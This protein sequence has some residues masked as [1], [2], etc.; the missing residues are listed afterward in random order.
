M[1]LQ[2]ILPLSTM[3]MS[4][5]CRDALTW[6]VRDKHMVDTLQAL[7]QHLQE[8]GVERPKLVVWAHNSHL[9]MSGRLTWASRVE[10]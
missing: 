7:D 3:L 5:V 4:G 8:G 2:V 6:N 1:Y 9:G 10:K